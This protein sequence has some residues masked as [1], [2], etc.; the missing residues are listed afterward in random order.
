MSETK[1]QS[2]GKS[3]DSGIGVEGIVAPPPRPSSQEKSDLTPSCKEGKKVIGGVVPPG[4]RTI[5]GQQ[6]KSSPSLA[7]NG[8]K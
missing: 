2:F 1:K 3:I 7:E 8:K 4:P 5:I 6:P